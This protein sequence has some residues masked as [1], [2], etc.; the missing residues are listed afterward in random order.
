[1]RE[2]AC[3]CAPVSGLHYGHRIQIQHGSTVRL[4]TES[5]WKANVRRIGFHVNRSKTETDEQVRPASRGFTTHFLHDERLA[6]LAGDSGVNGHPLLGEASIHLRVD[7][8]NRQRWHCPVNL[9]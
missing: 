1:M 2:S 6:K 4:A 5:S 3:G 9:Y 8:R 7:I